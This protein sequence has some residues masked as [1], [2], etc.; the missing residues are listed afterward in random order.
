M[1]K[2]NLIKTIQKHSAD[3]AHRQMNYIV[4]GPGVYLINFKK[5]CQPPE[6]IWQIQVFR[7][8]P[9]NYCKA[10]LRKKPDSCY[11]VKKDNP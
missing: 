6:S 8:K 11:G 3:E 9:L 7:R 10:R 2:K 4:V 1:R 5:T